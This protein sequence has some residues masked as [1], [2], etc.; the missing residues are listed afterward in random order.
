MQFTPFV[1]D[2]IVSESE[3]VRTFKLKPRDGALPAFLPGH[4]FLLGLTGAEG[5]RIFRSYSIASLPKEGVL[6]F[7]VK[8]KGIFTNMLWNLKAGDSVEVSGP[9]GLFLLIPD[10]TQ[11][12][13]VG[14]GVGIAPLR[15]M[16]LQTLQEGKKAYLF[17]SSRVFE[18]L[19]YYSQF[20][21]MQEEN[22]NFKFISCITRDAPDGW[23]GLCER[24][25]VPAIK[26]ELGTLDGKSYYF[27]GAK[28]MEKAIVGGL[29]AENV[30]KDKIRTESWG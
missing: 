23:K 14:G 19:T 16:I 13:F 5:K 9:F 15:A 21:K 17:H 4:F 8:L 29:L 20:K 7:C 3:Q 26:K 28:E 6:Q 1:I 22:P 2:E 25:S 12:V 27:C 24:L 10:D 11:R 30:P 18:E